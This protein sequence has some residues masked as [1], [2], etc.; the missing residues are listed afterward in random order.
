MLSRK[1]VLNQWAIF[2]YHRIL[3]KFF[4]KRYV[5]KPYNMRDLEAMAAMVSTLTPSL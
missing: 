5:F 3:L 4:L 1:I 2:S